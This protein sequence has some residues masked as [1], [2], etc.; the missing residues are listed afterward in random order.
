MDEEKK[1]KRIELYK[2]FM[3]KI[4][5]YIEAFKATENEKIEAKL[6]TFIK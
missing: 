2:K 5:F 1:Q 6:F 3:E 4:E